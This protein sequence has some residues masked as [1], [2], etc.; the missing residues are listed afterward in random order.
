MATVDGLRAAVPGLT[1]VVGERLAAADEPVD[2]R[3][4]RR[5]ARQTSAV[6]A[7]ILAGEPV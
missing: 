2:V 1:D 3:A 5:R 6:Q 7:R 4:P